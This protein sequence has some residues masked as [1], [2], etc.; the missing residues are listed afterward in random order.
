MSTSICYISV[1]DLLLH[2][3]RTMRG[4][5]MLVRAGK[6]YLS[7]R[8]PCMDGSEGKCIADN[9]MEKFC[10]LAKLLHHSQ[11]AV[12]ANIQWLSVKVGP[13]AM[14]SVAGILVGKYTR[15]NG[16]AWSRRDAFGFPPINQRKAYDII[17]MMADR[18]TTRGSSSQGSWMVAERNPILPV[19]Y[20][21]EKTDRLLD[22]L[23]Y[24]GCVI[25]WWH[26][27]TGEISKLV[28]NI[29]ACMVDRQSAEDAVHNWRMA[30]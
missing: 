13:H 23:Q 10:G 15:N 30:R 24:K 3:K 7:S 25:R 27:T 20:W 14:E 12:N 26:A 6:A 1:V 9:G 28:R 29:Q 21:S 11:Q 4:W 19:W 17:D 18:T 5:K 16:K 22:N 2:S 8:I